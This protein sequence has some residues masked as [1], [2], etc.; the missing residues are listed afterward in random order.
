VKFSERWLREFVDPDLSTQALVDQLTMAGLEVDGVEPV[1]AAL[2]GVVVGEIVAVNGHENA[3]KLLVCTVDGGQGLQQVVCGAPNARVGIKV[4]YA[5]IGAKLEDFKIKKAKLRGVESFG[6]LC[7][8]R[9]LGL[10]DNHDGL[11]ELPLEADN[12]MD[13]VDYLTL[14]DTCIEVDLTPNRGDCLG[15]KGIARETGLLNNLD[16]KVS[17]VAAVKSAIEDIFPV[18]L[19]C[20]QTCPRFVGRIIRDV[21]LSV[22]SPL[23]LREKLRRSGIRSIDSVVD[24]TNFVMLELNQP[25][26]AYDL[27]RLDNSITVRLSKG[28]EQM[29]LLDGSS[30]DLLEGTTL[31]TDK[32]GPVGMAGIM[33]GDRTAVSAETKNIFLEAAFFT[34]LGVAG[35]ARSYGMH[36]DACHRFERGVDYNGQ[37]DAIE[38]A[39]EL[40]LSIAGGKAGPTV[41]VSDQAQLPAKAAVKLR[42]SRVRRVLGTEIASIEIENILGRLDFSYSRIETDDDV[43]WEVLSPSHRFDI[44]IEADLIEEV[45]RVYGYNNLPVTTPVSALR[46]LEAPEAAVKQFSMKKMLAARGYHEAI[47]YSF[48]DE[49][50]QDLLN[51]NDLAVRLKNPLSADMAV[52]RTSLWSGLLKS[53]AYNQNRQQSRVRLFELGMVFRQSGENLCMESLDQELRISGVITG[54]RRPENWADTDEEVDF[55]DLKG[56]VEYLLGSDPAQGYEFHPCEHPALQ[57]GQSAR[58]LRNGNEVGY[59]GLLNSQVQARF[60]LRSP[61]YLFELGVSGIGSRAVPQ[62][63][64]VSRF[65]EI[66]R[67]IAVIVDSS[68]AS[69]ELRQ[70]VTSN[71][72]AFFHKLKLFDVYVGK[73]IENNSK[74]IGLGLTF[75]HPSRTLK[76][77]EVNSAMERIVT[78][79]KTELNAKLRD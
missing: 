55:Y 10:S 12:G 7:S 1:A 45:S 65:P 62:V 77:E 18:H 2:Q 20:P 28:G 47:T 21:D 69:S 79:M 63:N 44:A 35:K 49:D 70:V 29:T 59:L 78:V 25:M 50:L 51:S 13:I 68:I 61:C 54:R 52:M 36:T 8:E 26:H 58:V 27:D 37:V 4:P 43:C 14:D 16:L 73:G 72:G 41:D 23:W 46:M 34:P 64:E 5:T 42:S 33:G 22:P 75:Q 56:D 71:A 74:S 48:V 19:N 57:T 3:D 76:D 24:V 6:M 17:Q 9:E 32:S 39:S 60:D 66:R 11:M 67:D 53:A 40:L 38:R 30:V 31:I 15:I